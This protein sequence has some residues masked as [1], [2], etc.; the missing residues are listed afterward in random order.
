M[1]LLV[2]GCNHRSAELGLLERIAVP[3]DELPK[4]LH[5]VVALEHV[6]EAV[7]VSTCNR[8][9]VYA[10]VTRFHPGLQEV[11]GWLAERGDIH[12]QDLDALQYSYH[13]DRAAAH[14]FAVAGGL[15]SMVVGERQIA[16]QVKHAMEV[17]RGEGTARRV[18]Q[19]VF[20]QAVSVGRRIRNESRISE[21]ASSMVDVGL[22]AVDASRGIP[23]A[24]SR[25]AVV[26]AGDL[27]GLAVRRVADLGAG[28]VT[29]WNRSPD[30]A[31]RLATKLAGTVSHAVVSRLDAALVDAEVVVCTTGAGNTLIGSELVQGVL[32]Q[33]R[34]NAEDGALGTPS[35]LVLLD[36]GV[37]RNVDPACASLTGVELIDVSDV[38]RLAVRG[39]T[40]TVLADA[41]RI[42]EEEV[43]RFAAWTRAAEV[44]PTIRAI[45]TQAETVRQA[46]LERLRGKLATLDDQQRAAVD[47]LT[48]GIVN[49]L[50][51]HPTVRL[52]ELADLG[53]ADP[54][55][56]LLREL[57]DLPEGDA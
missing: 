37:P 33:R 32:E 47:S 29:I 38:R 13:D 57:F 10:Q 22:A 4:A 55:V 14:L 48:R 42:V 43:E 39:H 28:H 24:G 2:V 16:V 53:G 45:R 9:E 18:L 35:P 36:L 19:R 52:K 34:W 26:G 20:S 8:V 46:E 21:G 51:H 27:G 31:E 15:D 49:T 44:E 7:I 12:P 54:G 11:R 3:V 17:A 56:E 1:A 5:S 40:G 23:L 30:K 25:V 50:L 6:T 41:R